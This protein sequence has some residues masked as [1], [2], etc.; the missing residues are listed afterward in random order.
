[1]GK[2]VCEIQED[3]LYIKNP[4]KRKTEFDMEEIELSRILPCQVYRSIVPATRKAD[5]STCLFLEK[6]PGSEDYIMV[7]SSNEKIQYVRNTKEEVLKIL[8]RFRHITLSVKMNRQKLKIVMLAYFVN[9]REDLKVS[10]PAIGIGDRVYKACPIKIRDRQLP[11]LKLFS[12]KHLIRVTF[13]MK[14]IMDDPEL[15]NMIMAQL[16]VEGTTVHFA[17]IKKRLGE[18]ASRTFYAPINRVIA[19]DMMLFL[20]RNAKGGLTLV[21][22]F[23]DEY[24]KTKT[25]R[26]WESKFVSAVLYHGGK[27]AGKISGKPVNLFFEKESSKTEEG[28]YEVFTLAQKCD[29]SKNYFIIDPASEDYQKIKA[30]PG[31]VRKYSPKYY[32][33]LYRAGTIISTEAAAHLNILR[34]SNHYLRTK[35]IEYQ[36]IF[37]QHGVTYMKCHGPTSAFVRGREAEPEYIFAGSQKERDVIVDMLRIPEENVI[38]TGLPIFSTIEHEHIDQ[39]SEDYVT[40]MLTFKPYEERLDSFENSEYYRAVTDLY[41]IIKSYIPEDRILIVAHPRIHYLLEKTS[42]KDRMWNKPIS[43]VLKITKLLVTDYSS[44]AYNSFYQGAGVIFYQQD[45][46]EYEEICGKLIPSEEEYIGYRAFDLK[47][48]EQIIEKTIVNGKIDLSAAR[49]EQHQK[50]YREINAYSDGKNVE[51]IFD[52]LKKRKLI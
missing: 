23:L 46:R 9:S 43:Q 29:T 28:A 1:M 24:E 22:R 6:M 30:N 51:R 39:S 26:F 27:L 8:I 18:G 16:N 38:I 21:K 49:T 37:L 40:I 41:E 12:P 25:Y 17:I 42:M 47:E 15:S 13:P 52:E 10:E 2:I 45:I 34:S 11:T 5:W 50:N 44:V 32:W 3:K 36:F 20:R 19:K 31:V 48:F 7:F 33:V 35:M 4:R 14:E